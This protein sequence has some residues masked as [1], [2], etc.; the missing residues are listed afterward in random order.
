MGISERQ[1]IAWQERMS[2][3]FEQIMEDPGDFATLEIVH[4]IG[5]GQALYHELRELEVELGRSLELGY[6]SQRLHRL[7]V[8]YR[9]S[10]G[11]QNPT[12]KLLQEESLSSVQSFSSRLEELA[13]QA[14][15]TVEDLLIRG[16]E[17]LIQGRIKRTP[18]P[19]KGQK[20]KPTSEGPWTPQVLKVEMER[21]GVSYERMGAALEPPCGGPSVFKWL[22][23]G[24]PQARQDQV[25][26]AMEAFERAKAGR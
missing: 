22:T 15:T 18:G 23:K 8:R 4:A 21:L 1:V 13:L 26:R 20:R 12:E 11:G 17:A 2:V 6:F 10:R 16:A 5:E 14:G 19:Q 24:I 25:T 9:G 7:E 3:R